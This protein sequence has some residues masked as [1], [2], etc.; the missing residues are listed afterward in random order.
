MGKPLKPWAVYW[1]VYYSCPLVKVKCSPG[2]VCAALLWVKRWLGSV[3]GWQ[4]QS[5]CSSV[6]AKFRQIPTDSFPKRK[7]TAKV[8]FFLLFPEISVFNGYV[9]PRCRVCVL[10]RPCDNG[11][12]TWKWLKWQLWWWKSKQWCSSSKSRGSNPVHTIWLE[13]LVVIL[14]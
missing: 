14:T 12:N 13:F 1:V 2:V 3:S 8:Y 9:W 11:T 5:C 6:A 4:R 7:K 10:T